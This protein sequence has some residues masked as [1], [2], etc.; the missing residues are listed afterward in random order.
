MNIARKNTA[1]PL[2]TAPSTRGTAEMPCPLGVSM[3]VTCRFHSSSEFATLRSNSDG[4]G[5]AGVE[6]RPLLAGVNPN[7]E[8]IRI[9]SSACRLAIA[10]YGEWIG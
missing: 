7:S 1:A 3:V 8:A 2:P 10:T 6:I 9:I 5:G 4:C